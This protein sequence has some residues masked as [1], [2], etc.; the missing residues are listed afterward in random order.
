MEFHSGFDLAC[1]D[2]VTARFQTLRQFFRAAEHAHRLA[3]HGKASPV[4]AVITKIDRMKTRQ[5]ESLFLK[6]ERLISGAGNQARFTIDQTQACL[7]L[8][9]KTG[10]FHRFMLVFTDRPDFLDQM[11]EQLIA[12]PHIDEMVGHLSSVFASI[13]E[14]DPAAFRH[15][16]LSALKSG[17]VHVIHAASRNLRVFNGA[18]EEDIA[19]IQAYAGYPDPV[20][21][22]GAIFAI[23]YTGKFTELRQNLKEAVLSIHTEEIRQLPQI[24]LT[25]SVRM[26]FR[27]RASRE[28]KQQ[29]SPQSSSSCAIGI[30]TKVPYR[31]S[32]AGL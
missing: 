17:A 9:V 2:V 5:G 8:R 27:S 30:S 19:V 25:L 26:V 18:T 14:A 32:S 31:V 3:V 11:A 16:A 20:V 7:E 4:S 22:R 13:H 24:S 15:R 29:V 28:K 1:R 12:N 23:T 21:K 10:G 6:V